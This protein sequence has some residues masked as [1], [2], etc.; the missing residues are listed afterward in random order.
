MPNCWRILSKY[1][2]CFLGCEVIGMMSLQIQKL[3]IR[4]C[5][6]FCSFFSCILLGN[7][8]RSVTFCRSI[9][10]FLLSI[11]CSSCF[12]SKNLLSYF[13]RLRLPQKNL[14]FTISTKRF[15]NQLTH[16]T[17]SFWGKS[18]QKIDNN[19]KIWKW[20]VRILILLLPRK[21]IL[22]VPFIFSSLCNVAWHP[23]QKKTRQVSQA[24]L[25][26]MEK[27]KIRLLV[28]DL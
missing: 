1:E 8:S 10:T 26:C 6:N 25:I 18:V 5:W 16:E 2:K 24:W 14:S 13:G 20:K 21:M 3:P 4:H 15:S 11:P 12:A 23:H 7:L 9:S 19:C 28:R 17:S 27:A 22:S